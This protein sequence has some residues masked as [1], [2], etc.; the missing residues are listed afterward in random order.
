[1][2]LWRSYSVGITG[3]FGFHNGRN[4]SAG[5]IQ[6][7]RLRPGNLGRGVDFQSTHRTPI[8][9]L[10]SN[11]TLS[12]VYRYPVLP[13]LGAGGSSGSPLNERQMVT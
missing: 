9:H 2:L 10:D 3:A 1:V 8:A 12:P 6:G 11:Q 13:K 4:L 7:C 5:D